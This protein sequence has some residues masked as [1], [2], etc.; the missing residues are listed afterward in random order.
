M[1]KGWFTLKC[2]IIYSPSC[3]VTQN[4]KRIYLKKTQNKVT[5]HSV[6]DCQASKRAHKNGLFNLFQGFR[7]CEKQNLSNYSLIIHLSELRSEIK[8]SDSG[9]NLSFQ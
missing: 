5:I 1:L 6:H 2:V 9:K 3:F 4:T 7:S 8:E